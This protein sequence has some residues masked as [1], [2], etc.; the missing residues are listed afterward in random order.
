MTG[1]PEE[2]VRAV[3]VFEMFEMLKSAS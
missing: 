2:K 1:V 3:D